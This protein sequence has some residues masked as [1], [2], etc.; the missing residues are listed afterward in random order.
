MKRLDELILRPIFIY[1]YEKDKEAR[2]RDFYEL[3]QEEGIDKLF[4]QQ[5]LDE[6]QKAIAEG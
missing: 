2:A 6:K 5:A 3:F 4:Q 1:K